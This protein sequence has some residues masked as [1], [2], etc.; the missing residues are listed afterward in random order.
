MDRSGESWVI[1]A[2]EALG[3]ACRATSYTFGLVGMP[4]PRSR[5]CR[6]P[7]SAR[8]RTARTRKSL[9]ARASL[10]PAGKRQSPSWPPPGPPGSCPYRPVS[11]RISGKYSHIRAV[12]DIGVIRLFT[13]APID[14]QRQ[15]SFVT[16]Y[17]GRPPGFQD[18]EDIRGR[19]PAGRRH[20][21]V[22]RQPDVASVAITERD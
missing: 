11:I 1:Q 5:N 3:S 12:F 13:W 14:D 18:H 2:S 7:C 16:G 17:L 21:V 19:M 15:R 6:I 9:L 10:R 20:R 4:V 22:V 8:N